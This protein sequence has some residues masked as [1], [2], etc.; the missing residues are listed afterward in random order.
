[1]KT[2]KQRFEDWMT[3]AAY[4]DSNEPEMGFNITGHKTHWMKKLVKHGKNALLSTEKADEPKTDDI[5]THSEPQQPVGEPVNPDRKLEVMLVDD[6]PIVG[7]R[8]APALKKYGYD[9]EV[10][11][12]PVKA[13]DRFREK[14]FDVVVTDMR[15]E[16]LNGIQVLEQV[17]ARSPKTKVIFITGYATVEN[18]REALVKGA[19]DFIAKP[20]K[21]NDLRMAIVKAAMSLGYRGEFAGVTA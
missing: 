13:V 7:K 2:L 21:P 11:E 9:V 14:E 5:Y 1:M 18:A 4:A 20:F 6:E 3:I 19:F 16:K 17:M 12:N 8:L 15:M 10:F